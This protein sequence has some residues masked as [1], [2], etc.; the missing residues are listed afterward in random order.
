MIGSR[1]AFAGETDKISQHFSKKFIF[2]KL[3]ERTVMF[4]AGA[5]KMIRIFLAA[6]HAEMLREEDSGK[7]ILV[8]HYDVTDEVGYWGNHKTF[9]ASI[10]RLRSKISKGKL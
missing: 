6:D 2:E 7:F 10:M 1:R 3:N 5:A 9:G 4:L 8:L